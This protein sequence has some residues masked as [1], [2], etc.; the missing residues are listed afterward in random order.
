MLN[1]GEQ[2]PSFSLENQNGEVITNE[3][4]KGVKQSYIS[5]QETIH[6]HVQLKHVTLETIYQI[7]MNLT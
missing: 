2:F 4:L 1:K 7:L 6:R 3:T 5:I